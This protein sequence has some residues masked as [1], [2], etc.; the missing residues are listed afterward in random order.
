MD[1]WDEIVAE[2]VEETTTNL[3]QMRTDLTRLAEGPD[4]H[5]SL[6]QTHRTFHSLKGLT[7][8]LEF[9]QMA[10]LAHLGETLLHGLVYGERVYNTEIGVV[11]A[12]VRLALVVL[13]GD[14]ARTGRETPRDVAHLTN[15]LGSLLG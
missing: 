7:G 1:E 15:R 13:V 11:L 3:A 9:G 2:F 6:V 12:D 8:F 4:A 14:V 5:E 10:Q